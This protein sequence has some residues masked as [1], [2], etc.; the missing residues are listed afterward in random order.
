MGHGSRAAEAD[1]PEGVTR[2]LRL[3]PEAIDDTERMQRWHAQPGAG[4]VAQLRVQAVLTAIRRL[5]NN[6]C[7]P[8]RGE[9]PGTRQLVV[10][11][12]VVIY[13]V[14]PDT[15]RNA[16]VGPGQAQKVC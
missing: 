15:G 16:T 4:A 1:T 3:A 6:P 12:H 9:H 7:L 14:H 5:R 10:A 13:E 11:G 2:Q 8:R